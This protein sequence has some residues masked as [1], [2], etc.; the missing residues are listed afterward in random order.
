MILINCQEMALIELFEMAGLAHFRIIISPK[1]KNFGGIIFLVAPPPS[2]TLVQAITLSQIHVHVHVHQSNSYSPWPLRSQTTRTLLILASIGKTKWP[3]AAILYK[4]AQKVC[5]VSN[6]VINSRINLIFGIA[7][8]NTYY[9][10]FGPC[11]E[12]VRDKLRGPYERPYIFLSVSSS[13]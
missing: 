5:G 3:L 6:C 12:V 4:N 2:Q 7:I 10:R 13:N 9:G 11:L 1:F 8:D